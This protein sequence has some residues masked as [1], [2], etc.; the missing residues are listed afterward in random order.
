M[1]GEGER[2]RC[3][4]FTVD[5]GVKFPDL[6]ATL[7]PEEVFGKVLTEEFLEQIAMETKR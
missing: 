1:E 3:F 2:T 6:N 4:D 7:L 5:P